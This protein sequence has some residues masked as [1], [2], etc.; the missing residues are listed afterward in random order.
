RIPASQPTIPF[1]E[2]ELT[3]TPLRCLQTVSNRLTGRPVLEQSDRRVESRRTQVRVPLSHGEALMPDQLLHASDRRAL[4][5]Q[6]R[7]ERVT[8]DV[9]AGRHLRPLGRVANP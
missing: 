8:Q 4:H 2:F 5:R 1:Y 7:A 3:F 6:V 9:N